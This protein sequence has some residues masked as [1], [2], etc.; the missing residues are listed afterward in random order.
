MYGDSVKS[1]QEYD[2]YMQ[3]ERE[4]VN[5]KY[6][7]FELALEIL[8]DKAPLDFRG[9]GSSAGAELEYQEWQRD[10]ARFKAIVEDLLK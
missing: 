1:R 6:A 7:Q 3:E 10:V 2:E 8:L 4:V 5:S 9:T